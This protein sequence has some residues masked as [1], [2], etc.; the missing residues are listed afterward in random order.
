M[1]EIALMILGGILYTVVGAL[2]FK[3]RMTCSKKAM[4]KASLRELMPPQV[5][6]N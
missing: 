3:T 6:P 4:T 1:L 2:T 5:M